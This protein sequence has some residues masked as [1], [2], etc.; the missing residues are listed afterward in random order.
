[1]ESG[2]SV[3]SPTHTG[4]ADDLQTHLFMVQVPAVGL[5]RPRQR[6]R[7][8]VDSAALDTHLHALE[9]RSGMVIHGAPMTT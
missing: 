3:A 8:R 1:M 9:A 6:A 2:Q 7:S 5:P 4:L